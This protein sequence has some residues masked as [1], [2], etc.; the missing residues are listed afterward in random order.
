MTT[1]AL[2]ALG[3]FGLRLRYH[4][5][6]VHHM[7]QRGEV[8]AFHEPGEECLYPACELVEVPRV[9][10]DLRR[11]TVGKAFDA[12][13]DAKRI[14]SER[15]PGAKMVQTAKGMPEARFVPE[16]VTR[17]GIHADVVVCPR[18]RAYGASK[19][20]PDWAWLVEQL[21]AA[22]LKVFAA[23]APDTSADVE[24]DRA[25]DRERFLDA[26]VEAM[27]SA[28]LVVSTDA[29]LAHLAVL[30]GAP[31]LLITHDGLVAPGPVLDPRGNAMEPAY[32]PVRLEEYY[33]SAN[34]TGSPI[35]TTGSWLFRKSVRD[36]VLRCLEGK[37]VA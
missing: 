29:G 17:Y 23:G 1:V 37:A 35:F 10:D 24:C 12:M 31:L 5:P 7:A 4:V 15:W 32:W 26:S 34:H 3:E 11:G 22:G 13:E 6:A 16:P 18:W 20:W 36:Q 33:T 25:W 27:R 19:N 28:R 9:H 30:C 14:A 2:P 8:V 21:S